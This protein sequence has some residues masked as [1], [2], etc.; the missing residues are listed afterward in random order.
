[1]GNV[2]IHPIL[3]EVASVFTRVGKQVF[4]VGGAVRDLFLGKE[5]QDWDLAT[6]ARPEEVTSLF[7]RVI[8]T[9]IKHG[10]VT[11]RYKGYSMEVTTFRTE[12]TYSD[13]R[14]PDH[15]EYAA[16][17][18]EDLSRRDLTMN[19]IAL[20][21][22]G[23][24][25]VDPFQGY[26]DI[27]ARRIRCVGNAEERFREDGLRPLRAVRFASQLGFTVDDATLAAIPGALS[28]TAKVSPERIRDELEKIL[29]SQKPS[30]ALLLMEKAG[31]LELL[32]PELTA[33]RGIDQKGFHRFDVLDHSLLAC[34]YA[35]RQKFSHEVRLASLFHDIGKPMVRKLDET[36]V[37]TFYQ[38]E[39][40]S[41]RLA[42]NIGLRFR[43]PNAVIDRVVHLVEEH[44]FHYEEIWSDAAVRRLIIRVGKE[45]LDDI[46]ALR[47][48]DAYATAGTEPEP[49]F[50]APLVS[51]IDRIL[52][53]GRALS[54]KDLAISGEDLMD[55]GVARGPHIGIILKELLEAALDDPEL[56]TREKLL[57]IAGKLNGRYTEGK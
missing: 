26:D 24:E 42:R 34:D 44:M 10:T 4:L 22:P 57:E 2:V 28:T 38:H 16:T 21:L 43:Y 46:Y 54:L 47:Q 19:A 13:G 14:R 25:R 37:W 6:N 7:R 30:T 32:L 18:E 27:K 1:M 23:G 33:C 49:G 39:K 36:G 20:A 29:S 12:S 8:P 17:I 56:N 45:Y 40:V 15:I 55:M 52:A 11:I 51:R 9:G 41:A 35:A 5:A 3:K 50:L 48:A 31:L 53:Q